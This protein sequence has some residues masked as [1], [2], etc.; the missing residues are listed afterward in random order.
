MWFLKLNS[1]RLPSV[2]LEYGLFYI[3]IKNCGIQQYLFLTLKNISSLNN[4]HQEPQWFLAPLSTFWSPSFIRWSFF[5]FLRGDLPLLSAHTIYAPARALMLALSG[6]G[7]KGIQVLSVVNLFRPLL[8]TCRTHTKG[9]K[10]A[11]DSDGVT[12]V[13]GLR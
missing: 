4:Q 2:T 11:G 12:T 8:P 9:N 10:D 13:M 1:A 7:R 5:K 6:P 3:F